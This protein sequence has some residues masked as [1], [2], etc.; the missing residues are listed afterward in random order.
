M[1]ISDNEL[2]AF[3]DGQL[4]PADA[5]RVEQAVAADPELAR[6]LVDHRL[7][8]DRLAGHFAPIMAEVPPERLTALLRPQPPVVDLAA[9]REERSQRA[10]LPRWTWVAGPAL[11]ASLLIAVLVPGNGG[12]PS[13]VYADSQLAAVLDS[14]LVA[15]QNPDAQTRVLLSFVRDDGDY[16]RAYASDR[17]SGIACN[18]GTGWALV[19][20]AAGATGSQGEYQQAGSS[21]A[22]VLARAQEMAVGGALDAGAELEARERGWHD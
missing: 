19:E 14:Q 4:S 12:G 2:A 22:D 17:Q 11:A 18:D 8:K 3:A 1:T 9:A 7:L 6:R 10:R 20:Q 13:V 15:D 16:C 21:M 5:A